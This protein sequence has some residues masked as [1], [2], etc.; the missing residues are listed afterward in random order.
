MKKWIPSRLALTRARQQRR[1]CARVAFTRSQSWSQGT[2]SA[3]LHRSW[4]SARRRNGTSRRVDS[5]TVEAL[6]SSTHRRDENAATP[7]RKTQKAAGAGECKHMQQ[8]PKSSSAKNVAPTPATS[9]TETTITEHVR[10]TEAMIKAAK[11][12]Q[13]SELS[14]TLATKPAQAQAG[15]AEARPPRALWDS[16]LVS[17]ERPMPWRSKNRAA[18]GESATA[19]GGTLRPAIASTSGKQAS[20]LTAPDGAKEVPDDQEA[21]P[22]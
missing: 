13:G 20:G 3:G 19:G 16:A 18:R 1:S 9:G 14:G 2:A 15:R 5:A 12:M 6:T 4:Q 8:V 11:E 17:V 7:L 10:A 22:L 21:R